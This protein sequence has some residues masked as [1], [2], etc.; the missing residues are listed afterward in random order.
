MKSLHIK[1]LL[2]LIGAVACARGSAQNLRLENADGVFSLGDTVRVWATAMD[3]SDSLVFRKCFNSPTAKSLGDIGF[4]VAPEEFRPG[5]EE[6]Q[7][8]RSWWDSEISGKRVLLQGE[9]QG[10]AQSIALAGLDPRVGA[11]VATVPAMTDL[12]GSLQGRQCEWPFQDRPQIPLSNIGRQI[13]PYF[14]AALHLKYFKGLLYMEACLIDAT[15]PPAG[16][17]AGYNNSGAIQKEI[18]FFPYRGHTNWTCNSKDE[19]DRIVLRE[20]I[21]FIEDYLR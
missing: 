8:F 15:C 5:F 18:H 2:L 4:I 21:R 17:V 16:I 12:G 19:W 1:L 3:G 20:R 10:G 6:P 9:S 13:L 7:D 14:D 11:V